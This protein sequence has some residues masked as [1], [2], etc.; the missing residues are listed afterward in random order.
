VA[1]GKIDPDEQVVAY[2][3]GNGLKTLDAV[4]E[5]VRA[6][7]RVGPSLAAFEAAFDQQSSRG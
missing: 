1:A 2:I 3:T 6:P 5:H 4:A 7:L